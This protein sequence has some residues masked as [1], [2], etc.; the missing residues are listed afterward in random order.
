MRDGRRPVGLAA[1]IALATTAVAVLAVVLTGT[2][3]AGLVGGAADDEARRALGRQADVVATLF[4]RPNATADLRAGVARTI[5]A[6]RVTFVRVTPDGRPI[7]RQGPGSGH[8]LELPTEVLTRIGAGQDVGAARTVGGRR[9]IV[10][11]RPLDGGGAIAL[12]QPAAENGELAGAMLRRFG[13]AL[14]GGL[15]AATAVGLLLARRLARPLRRLAEVADQLAAGR[16]DRDPRSAVRPE[17]MASEH[18]A[19]ARAG[20]PARLG[21]LEPA[22]L[23]GLERLGGLRRSG[24]TERVAAEPVTIRSGPAEVADVGAALDG[25]AAALAESE[26]RQRRFL[27]SVS[28]ELRTPLTAVRGFAEALA[29]AVTEPADVASTGRIILGEAQRLD[30]LVSDLLDLARLGAD[31][32]RVDLAEVDLRALVSEAAA[33]WRPRCAAAGVRLEVELPGVP[34]PART[35]PMRFRQIVDG[36]AENALRV[37]PAGQPVVIAL[38]ADPVAAPVTAVIE[39]RDGGPGLTDD[40]LAV[41]FER[42]AL[43]ERYRGRRPVSTG[44][45]LALV[46]GLTRRLGGTPFAGHAPEGGAAFGVSLPVGDDATAT[47]HEGGVYAG[48]R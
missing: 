7:T 16:R 1:R 35:D 38:R 11:A 31:D 5:A 48:D 26:D 20:R 18:A 28:H 23:G 8:G 15:A 19:P 43:F 10:A 6:Q 21:G 45:G 46:A 36:L 42:S 44:V 39:V 33:V 2:I 13:I 24:R 17:H 30:R 4:A 12:V 37:V 3:F 34:V 47:D 32:F 29:D 14:A 25:L 27:L 22:R 41:A 9:V 40:D